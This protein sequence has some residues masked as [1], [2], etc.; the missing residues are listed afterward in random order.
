MPDP[1]PE[2]V[3]K[4]GIAVISVRIRNYRCLRAVTVPLGTTTVLIG[5]N[6][7]GKTSFIEA[8]HAAI[9]SGVKSLAE[10]DIFLDHDETSPPK[11]RDVTIDLLIRPVD[12]EGRPLA[13]FPEGSPWTALW[14]NGIAQDD[15][16]NDLVIIRARL[17]WSPT[18]S[19][20]VPERYFL[21]EWLDTEEAAKDAPRM[22]DQLI[23]QHIEP[24]ALFALDAKRDVVEDLRS[25]SS[26]WG[27]LVSD[28]GLPPDAIEAIE[29]TLSG[30]NEAIVQGSAVLSHVESHLHTVASILQC[31]E[32]GIAIT[33]VP[34]HLRDL[35]RGMDVRLTLTGASS[36]S[37]AKQ[38]MGTR[39]LATMLLFQA[40]MTWK[41]KTVKDDALHPFVS[42]EEPEVHL[43]PQA[44]RALFE[45]LRRIPGQT[46]LS[47]HSP[48]VSSQA[49]ISEFL[50]FMKQG[51]HTSV[52]WFT[53]E[54]PTTGEQLLTDEDVR[55]IN[56]EVMN[57]RGDIL[58]CR[59]LVLFEGETE[60]QAIP[61]FAKL[62]W[63][64]HPNE[65]G[66]S[67]VGVGGAG[68]YLPFLRLAKQ[69]RIPWLI[70]S[71]G[72]AT[73][74]ND[75]DAALKKLKEPP[76][77]DNKRVI[78]LPAGQS[79]EDYLVTAAPEY[80]PVIKSAIVDYR[81]TCNPQHREALQREWSAKTADNVIQELKAAKTQYGAR[82]AS[83]F[84][85]IAEPAL[86]IPDK[87]RQ[88][89]DLAVPPRPPTPEEARP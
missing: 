51:S 26:L 34:R 69:F 22:K 13:T 25:R 15:S 48:Y 52:S 59:C 10:D 84:G 81:A 53:M 85:S 19:E 24:L 39:A 46:I 63:L 7:A 87:I 20:Y 73:A 41:Q 4:S 62:Y 36:F 33:P 30:L 55:R 31:D 54:D 88:A 16:G 83:A 89:L 37:L 80:L 61:E 72:N 79:L 29:R 76:S 28:P 64:Q 35:N 66:I 58:Y 8:I 1:A 9:G 74:I 23:I 45:R 11:D 6:N 82:L 12:G 27:K 21:R 68:K 70:L 49:R 42:I 77:A 43:H 3:L 65:L 17:A 67:F 2:I 78:V 44:Q 18:R 5:E 50:H 32:K 47:T 38:G 60:E 86:R 40:Y 14:G 75:L 71:D 57:T 56:R